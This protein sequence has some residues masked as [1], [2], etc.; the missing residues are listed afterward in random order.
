MEEKSNNVGPIIKRYNNK[1][2]PANPPKKIRV[3]KNGLA[4]GTLN[5]C[6]S[7]LFPI[8]KH[9]YRINQDVKKKYEMTE[10]INNTPRIIEISAIIGKEMTKNN[11]IFHGGYSKMSFLEIRDSKNKNIK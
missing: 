2:D 3:L 9:P 5:V 7:T 8:K 10:I 4:F 1:R 6:L 11:P